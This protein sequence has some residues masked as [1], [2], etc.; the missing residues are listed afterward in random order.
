MTRQRGLRGADRR[1]MPNKNAVLR[2]L[3]VNPN[4]RSP[5]QQVE[6]TNFAPNCLL[7]KFIHGLTIPGIMDLKKRQ[8]QRE[9]KDLSTE[10]FDVGE[11][12]TTD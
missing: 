6:P 2:E 3:R 9:R 11:F 12:R 10:I 4:L 8:V 7:Y 1:S 5:S